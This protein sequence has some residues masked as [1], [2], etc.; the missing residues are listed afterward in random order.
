MHQMLKQLAAYNVW[1]NHRITFHIL[2]M[3]E[4]TWMQQTPSSFDNLYKTILHIWDAESGWW[5][6]MRNHE[7]VIMPSANFDPSMRDACNGLMHQS[8]QWEQ[9][10]EDNLS[11]EILNGNLYYHN[12]KG[13]SFS[14]PVFQIVLHVFNHST[15]HR[16]QLITMMRA[17]GEKQLPQTDFIHYARR[18]VEAS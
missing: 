16:G 4:A 13:D 12:T 11:E 15:Y 14:Q 9:F 1:A 6:R 7:K 10:I 8:M 5:Q 17:L 3:G 18:K 2:Q